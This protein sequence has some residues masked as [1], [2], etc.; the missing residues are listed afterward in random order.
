MWGRANHSLLGLREPLGLHE[1]LRLNM[2]KIIVAIT[3]VGAALSWWW[4]NSLIDARSTYS[5]AESA[6]HGLAVH[7]Q[8]STQDFDAPRYPREFGGAR[9]IRLNWVSKKD[10]KCRIEVDVDRGHANARPTWVCLGE[11]EK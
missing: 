7:M 8:M 5:I 6:F 2:K 4:L 9:N 1:N 11:K 10:P 3:L